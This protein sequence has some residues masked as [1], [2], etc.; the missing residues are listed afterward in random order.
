MVK[1]IP[2]I[3]RSTKIRF[4]KNTL[5]DQAENTIVFNASNTAIQANTPGAVYLE[6]IRNRPDYDDPQIVLLMYNRDT[7]EI[8]ESG[9]AATDIIETTLEGATIRGNVI[10]FSTVYFNNVEHASFVTDSNV[11]I[12]NT[13]PQH[14]LSIGSNVYF[15]D[16]GSNVL[17]VSGGVSID[18]NLDV[19]GGIT[20]I[21]SNNLIIE[22]AIIELG[23]NNTSGDTTL[24]LGLI[25]GR[26]GSNVTV[27]FREETDEIVL[28][29]TE[30]S[31]YSNAIVPLTSEDIN[32]H[33]Y[34]R[35]YTESNVGV[36]NTNPMHTL[37]VG[38]N[39]YVDEFGSN[40]LVVT[41]NTS[42]SGDLTVDTDT[43]FVDSSEN[44]VGIKTVTP[45]AELH[46]V[47]NVYV[48]SNLTVDEDTLHVD[49]V[50]DSIG[51]GTVNPKANLHVIGNVYVS[52]NLTVDEDTLHVDVVNDSIGLG[53]VNPKANLHVIGNVYVSSNLTVDEDTLHVDAGGKS[54]GLGTVNPKANLHVIGNVYV[55]SNLTVDDDT[56]HV[57]AGG[58]SIGLG[59]VNPK[60]NLHVVGNVYV[61][62]NL[63]VDEDTLHV[64]AG[65]K[66]IGLGTVNP[67]SNLH[68]V[69]NAYVSSNVT[70]DG[71][72]SLNHPTTALVTD[73]TSNVEVKLDQL[74]NVTIDTPIAEHLL[75]YDGSNWVN[76]FPQ[77]TYIQIRNDLNG[78]NI[79][80][81]DA[82]YVK[83]THNS[84][85]LNVGLA[86]SNS[87]STMPCIGLSNQLLTPGQEGTA[88][89]YGKA[90]SVVTDTFLAGETVYV[91]NTVPGGL[92]NVKPFYTDS[93]PNLIQNVGVVT[94]IH[95]SN[96]GVFVTGIGRA[97]DVPNAQVVLD[98]GDINWVY[99]NDENNDFK[100]IEPSNLLTQ[101]Q[102]FEQVSAAGNVVSNVIE[103]KNV[104][105]GLVTTSNLQVGSNISVT[106]LI[107]PNKKYLPMVD[108][109]GFFKQSPVYLTDT[110]KYVISASE[111]EFLGNITLSGNNTIISSTSVT[112]EDRI[113][114]IASNNA[115]TD[116][117]TGILIEHKDGDT[118]A[119]VALIYH[120]DDHRFSVGY[121]QNTFT[122]NHILHYQDP[123]GLV[124]DLLG[125]VQIQNSATLSS[126]LDVTGAAT[127]AND[128]TVGAVSNL[129][130]DVSTSRVGIN[131]ATPGASLDVGG[132]V[133]I[134]S[135]VNA[136]SKTS[137]A[138]VVA[139]GVGVG[140]D[141]YASN[142]VLSGNFTVDTDTL[143]VNSTT[144]RVGINKEVPDVALDVVGDMVITDDFTVDTDTLRVDSVTDRV[145][146]NVSAPD[147]S[148]HVIGNA[149][150]SSNL[151]VDTNT[152]HVDAEGNK[153]GILTVN[154]EFALD[155]HGTSNV[156]ALTATSLSVDTDTLHV[157]ATNKRVG[158]E[159][160][161]PEA[162]LHVV[163]NVIVT[164]NLT[165][166]TNTLHVDAEGNKVGILTVNPEFALD[167]HGTSNV[168][169]LTATSLSVDTDTLHV[170]ATN[171]RVGIETSSPE[172]NLHVVG[173][174]IVTSN[175]TVDTNT[176]HVD[177]EGNKVGIL[178]VNPEFAL[179][180]H[181]TSNVG[182]LTATSL[183][184]D[185]DTLHV[186]ATNKRV[187]IET[188]SPE[189]N[190]HVTGNVYV[191][192][193]LEVGASA[194]YVDTVSATSNVGIGTS[195]PEYSLDVVGDINFTGDLYEG[196]S[197][198]VSTPWEIESS[199]TAL[200][201][202][203]GNVGIG[204]ANPAAN[205]HVTGNVYVSSNLN[206]DANVFIAGGLVTN[207][208]GVTKKTYSQT[209]TITSGT[210]PDI[211]IVFSDHAFSAKITAQLIESD[212]E[213][214][215]LD[216]KVTGGRRGGA[217]TSTLNIAK[218]PL[219]IFGDATSNPWS[220][221]VGATTTT[222]TM[223]PSTNLDG[224]GHYN[225]F[226]EYV[227][228]DTGG[229]VS[230]IGGTST[231]Y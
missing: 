51:L 225:I 216:I 18:G 77:H 182:V 80:A 230:T 72:L 64:D 11:G 161:S 68:V 210:A 88:V 159:T 194:L 142:T 57:D 49:V 33:V 95:A 23:K 170:D 35:L 87:P 55:S 177:A 207:T 160:S 30:S 134:Q 163:G 165:V 148:L 67:T 157:D 215:T 48:S 143:I 10:N 178:T 56:L 195:A 219:S 180:V 212:I 47:G 28:A 29:F 86:Q 176:L 132:D 125:N 20:A 7:K 220:T 146:I 168:G 96:G 94:K 154:P 121:T 16:A 229:S 196:G 209:G 116:L 183:S 25:M 184:V 36:L 37:D 205:L 224:E 150:V 174:V 214:S 46:V 139:G 73:L 191:S 156:G 140:G 169:A 218:G 45:S 14:T 43:L 136:M 120:A 117:D 79:E 54:I 5:D 130:V 4:G 89:A 41:G 173:N 92:S 185:T 141:V 166:D 181:G 69:G 83:G 19:K 97:N 228:A 75:V 108:H 3:E 162:N 102:T 71:T 188:S 206:V 172:A 198:F 118:Y 186:D 131:E 44:K 203:K 98:E 74:S 31:A 2:T 211:A 59:T 40:I 76:D 6:P 126:T 128:L 61:S 52:S 187:G 133:N 189:A 222:V 190:L 137:A 217:S 42:V 100:K 167:V 193:N 204:D 200:S 111:A 13:N 15:N 70:T 34:G 106:G 9:E 151:T 221:T 1:N 63:T 53:T 103:F 101:L 8:T 62:S 164:S 81:G 171:K 17:V 110:G 123:G 226:V 122:D 192:A 152:L 78:V 223:T 155:V 145:G 201:Y 60:A 109:D 90:L 58:K 66:S 12:R 91:S 158:I 175:L 199:P 144:D 85:I 38:S 82:V 113:F 227:S 147:A 129:F 105:T 32:V 197:L 153:V 112:I 124:V 107:D 104:T 138:L 115:A 27:G 65:G 208:G 179:D 135:G 50:N 21:T 119:N 127:F 114:G 213:I 149:Y 202:E 39:L 26:P 93:V 99:V 24:D 84:N 22:D 231:G